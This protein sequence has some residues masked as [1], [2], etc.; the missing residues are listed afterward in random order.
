MNAL[1]TD[2]LLVTPFSKDDSERFSKILNDRNLLV[3]HGGIYTSRYAGQAFVKRQ[4]R[5]RI[6]FD[7]LV[8]RRDDVQSAASFFTDIA[9]KTLLASQQAL[10]RFIEANSLQITRTQEKAVE[11][12]T[13]W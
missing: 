11:S 4:T 8:I 6:F 7:S 12:L 3:H 9:K 1:Y 5:Q 2:L 10:L 13:M